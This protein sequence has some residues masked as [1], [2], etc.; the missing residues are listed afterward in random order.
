MPTVDKHFASSF[1][2]PSLLVALLL[3]MYLIYIIASVSDSHVLDYNKVLM[4]LPSFPH[5]H[6]YRSER[7]PVPSALQYVTSSIV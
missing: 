7:M 1:I 5:Q 2:M 4:K 6:T 3:V